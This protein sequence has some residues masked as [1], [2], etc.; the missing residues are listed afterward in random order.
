MNGDWVPW[1]GDPALYKAK[2]RLVAQ[3]FRA[4]APNVAMLWAPGYFPLYTMNDYYPGDDVVDWVGI[5]AYGVFDPSLDPVAAPG[6][7]QDSRNLSESFAE[8]YKLYA[9]RKP[10]MLA[11]GAIGSYNY[12]NNQATTAWAETNI[13]RFYAAMPRLYPRV[14]ALTWFDVDLGATASRDAGIMK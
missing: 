8:V 5:S 9:D 4:E 1:H 12:A 11:E 13:R 3:T 2:F 14:K 10:I 7:G 6:Q